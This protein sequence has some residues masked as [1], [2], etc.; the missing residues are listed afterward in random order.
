MK[1][2]C[3]AWSDVLETRER[4]DGTMRRRYVCANGHRYSTIELWF[5]YQRGDGNE[6]TIKKMIQVS[7]EEDSK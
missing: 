4:S 6:E 3:G 2:R 7:N 1:C 5:D